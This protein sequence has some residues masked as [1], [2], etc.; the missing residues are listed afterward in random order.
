MQLSQNLSLTEMIASESAKR[1]GIS[2]QPTAEHIENMKVL[3]QHIFQ[4][5]REVKL[6]I[7][8]WM[9][10]TLAIEMFL[11]LLKIT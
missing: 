8:I 7:L 9:V 4:P 6:W 10:L 3:A 1:K 5:I 11:C 2:N